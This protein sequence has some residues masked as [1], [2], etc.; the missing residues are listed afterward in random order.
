MKTVNISPDGFI[1]M[2]MNQNGGALVD[3]LDREMIKGNQAIFDHGGASS[4]T[5][6]IKLKK[7]PNM[8]TA[9]DIAHDVE[10]KHPKEDRPHGAMFVTPGSGLTDQYQKQE[11]LGLGEESK[12]VVNRLGEGSDNKVSRINN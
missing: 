11:S 6:K 4:I 9:V 10:A 3:E 7:I 12:P 5:L 8:D 1:N 2:L